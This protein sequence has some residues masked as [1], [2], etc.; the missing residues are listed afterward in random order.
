[1]EDVT[2]NRCDVFIFTKTNYE[3]SSSVEYHLW[4]K[5]TIEGSV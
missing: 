2:K 3:T 1:M 4:R 5:T